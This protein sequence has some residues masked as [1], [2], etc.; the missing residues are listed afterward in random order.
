MLYLLLIRQKSGSLQAENLTI[1][2]IISK[3]K[4]IRKKPTLAI[5]LKGGKCE[6]CGMET[7]NLVVHQ[8]RNL[9]E[10]SEDTEWAKF[11]KRINRKTLVVCND[12]HKLI[13]GADCE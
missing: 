9:K 12:C 10:L 13:H 7:E 5:R 6:W 11:M 1:N 4:G 3:P 8:V 2:N